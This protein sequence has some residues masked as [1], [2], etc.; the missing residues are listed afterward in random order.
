M[1]WLVF[2]LFRKCCALVVVKM[3]VVCSLV[4][5]CGKSLKKCRRMTA[6]QNDPKMDDE[7]FENT[8]SDL[9]SLT[10]VGVKDQPVSFYETKDNKCE[11][12]E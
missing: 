7:M 9:G 5:V 11:I 8:I 3:N 4:S 12:T 10:T 6:L 1:L 2:W